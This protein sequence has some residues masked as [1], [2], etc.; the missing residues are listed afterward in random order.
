MTIVN[1][2]PHTITVFPFEDDPT[3]IP[4]SGIVAR[5]QEFQSDA[6]TFDGLPLVNFSFGSVKNLPAEVPGT[7]YVVSAMV[8][9]AC[10]DRHDVASPGSFVRDESGAIIGC[11]NLI[12]NQ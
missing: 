5:C 10:P 11:Q 3:L 8:R 4:P 12:V 2:T 7:L 9:L 6:G 1:L